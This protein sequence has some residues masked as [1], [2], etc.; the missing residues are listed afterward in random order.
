[1]MKTFL[2]ILAAIAIHDLIVEADITIDLA[3]VL[4][5]PLGVG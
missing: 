2:E 1:M 3:V 4:L 5:L